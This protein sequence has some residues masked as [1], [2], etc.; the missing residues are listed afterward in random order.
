MKS[1][2]KLK[3]LKISGLIACFVHPSSIQAQIIPDQSLPNNSHTTINNNI[4]EITGGT[5]AG[6]NLFHSFQEFSLQTGNTAYFNNALTIQNIFSR[7]TGGNVSY[8]NGLLQTNGT[9]N[10]FF[11]N[12]NGII[13]GPNA[14][15]N[16]GG[17]FL[18]TTA[19]SIYFADGLKFS[20]TPSKNPLLTVNIP[21]GLEFNNSAP[22]QINSQGHNLIVSSFP[23]S[24]FPTEGLQVNSG[25]T[26]AIL[27]GDI[28]LNGGILST[29]NGRVELGAIR[30]G[31]VNINFS[32]AGLLFTYN[33]TDIF[34]DIDLLNKSLILSYGTFPNF[35]QLQGRNVRVKDDSLIFIQN[36]SSSFSGIK[37]YASESV[38]V[39]GRGLPNNP[40]RSRIY[41]E[42]IGFG[43][44]ANIEIITPKFTVSDNAAVSTT[45]FSRGKG[46]DID[47]QSGQVFITGGSAL[48]AGAFSSGNG[49]K[50]TIQA[51]D[52][53]EVSGF[54]EGTVPT[55]LF[56]DST[57]FPSTINTFSVNTGKAGN[58]DIISSSINLTDGGGVATN[59]FFSTGPSGNININSHTIKLSGTTPQGLQSLIGTTTL[60]DADA[61]N[62]NLNTVNLSV[63]EGGTITSSTLARGNAGT[64]MINSSQSVTVK[65]SQL[66]VSS[67]INSSALVPSLRLQDL[68]RLKP[69]TIG[70]SGNIIINTKEL[71]LSNQGNIAVDNQVQGSGGSIQINAA[72]LDLEQKGLITATTRSNSGGNINITSQDLRLSNSQISTSASSTGNGGNININTNFLTLTNN[73]QINANAFE[74]AGGN[75]KVNTLGL[76]TS[77]GSDITA[78][79]QLGINGTV[80]INS[81]LYELNSTDVKFPSFISFE[82]VAAVSCLNNSR[83]YSFSTPGRGGTRP[84][85]DT[86]TQ[87]YQIEDLIPMGQAVGLV[88]QPDG[89]LKLVGCH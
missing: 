85:P 82:N 13:F 10:L 11:L 3:F 34:G 19:S 25:K 67:T 29:A 23:V 56:S 77:F 18:A 4:I 83:T 5:R 16:I 43:Q 65:G 45:T 9:A 54:A 42:M 14:A 73:S 70:E 74:G 86:R 49:G 61:G 72:R 46:G 81:N 20:S 84:T 66:N 63:L 21:I 6:T 7:V 89:R 52:L 59:S 17:S 27:G 80:T 30:S 37:I 38:T 62:I 41:T 69:T 78:S 32:D 76:F 40:L 55:T 15:L 8:I 48:A 75:I 12:P 22:I 36:Q 24:K 60:G 53:I 33:P 71:I 79:S 28:S 50:I 31:K 2:L 57:N 26:L 87:H 39:Q 68:L 88:R 47:L 64:I 35:I 1:N 51:G 44:G 58:I